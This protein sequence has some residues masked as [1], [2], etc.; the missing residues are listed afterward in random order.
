MVVIDVLRATTVMVEALHAGA[1]CILPCVEMAEA[2]QR[3]A[4]EPG[5]ALLTGERHGVQLPGF[6]LGNSPLDFTPAEVA[7]HTI[8]MTT[9][10]GT[11]ALRHACTAHRVLIAAFTNLASVSAALQRTAA[12]VPIHLI[13]AGTD[14]KPTAEDLLLAGAITER[15]TAGK[16]P[17]LEMN[18]E[19]T[20]AVEQ[21]RSIDSLTSALRASEG[22]RNLIALGFDADIEHAARVDRHDRVPEF[23]HRTLRV[24]LPQP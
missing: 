15:L 22:G 12:D 1:T 14:G 19:A 20:R 10:N 6:D 13:C 24:T 11:K 2:R 16:Y 9:T 3:H 23:D 7:G 17:A 18:R 4:A 21:W 5:P 8:V